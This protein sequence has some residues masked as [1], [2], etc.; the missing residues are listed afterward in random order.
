MSL[1]KIRV[2]PDQYIV[3]QG[4]EGE[5]AFLVISGG[6]VAEVNGKKVGK[7]EAGEIFGEL[8]LILNETRKASIKAIVPSEIVEI[9]KKALEAILLS[10]NIELHKVINEM[11]KEL[12]KEDD[13]K[14]P[15]SK[16]DLIELSKE[17]PN[18]IRAL[19][20][21]LHYRLSQRIFSK[22]LMLEGE[23]LFDQGDE[24]EKAYII[25]HGGVDVIVDGKK[26]G[27][28][29]EGEVFGE[30]ALILNQKR[31]AKIVSNQ[32]TELILLNKKRLKELINSGSKNVKKVIINLCKELSKRNEFQNVLYTRN[33]L[34]VILEQENDIIKRLTFQIFYRLERS[35]TH[36]E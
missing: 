35:T 11:S 4:Q 9:K 18:V 3:K 22:V 21:Q 27:V 26:I 29:G 17:S 34:E 19:A 7:I 1:K 25:I 13:Q 30:L 5:T 10:S 14:L 33:E 23:T 32:S 6:L 15:I 24:G 20:L 8:S 31:S 2:L 12:G 28:M 16:T 36:I